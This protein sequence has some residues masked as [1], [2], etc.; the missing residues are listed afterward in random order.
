MSMDCPFTLGVGDRSTMVMDISWRVLASQYARHGPAIPAPEM[1][2]FILV[3]EIVLENLLKADVRSTED[4][5][6][7]GSCRY[8]VLRISIK[9]SDTYMKATYM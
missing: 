3:A 8:I 2:T 6:S 4:C 5:T 1:S 9:A 7:R